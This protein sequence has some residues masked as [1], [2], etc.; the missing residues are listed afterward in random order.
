M[1]G[2]LCCSERDLGE[3]NDFGKRFDNKPPKIGG[4]VGERD[5]GEKNDLSERYDKSTLV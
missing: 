2:E 4:R 1:M 5:L 3:K